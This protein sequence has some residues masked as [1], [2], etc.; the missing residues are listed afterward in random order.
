MKKVLSLIILLIMFVSTPVFSACSEESGNATI[1]SNSILNGINIYSYGA[2]SG[3]TGVQMFNYGVSTFSVTMKNKTGAKYFGYN[4][5]SG[6]TWDSSKSEVCC[7]ALRD[8]RYTKGIKEGFIYLAKLAGNARKSGTNADYIAITDMA[9]RFY[10]MANGISNGT[11]TGTGSGFFQLTNYLQTIYE[12]YNQGQILFGGDYEAI[13]RYVN[14]KIASSKYAHYSLHSFISSDDE[15]QQNH[16]DSLVTQAYNLYI[17]AMDKKRDVENAGF[18]SRRSTPDITIDGS[19]TAINCN[20]GNI[21]FRVETE[22]SVQDVHFLINNNSGISYSFV[23]NILSISQSSIFDDAHCEN[24]S[25]TISIQVTYQGGSD[26]NLYYCSPTSSINK[27]N[28]IVYVGSEGTIGN[29]S[30]TK[31]YN[32]TII[33]PSKCVPSSYSENCY[34][35]EGGRCIEPDNE[36]DNRVVIKSSINNCCFDPI[37]GNTSTVT[38]A[39]ESKSV[40]DDL[41][42]NDLFLF[43]D[44]LSNPDILSVV[45]CGVRT[46]TVAPDFLATTADTETMR[47]YCQMYCMERTQIITPPPVT[48]TAGRYFEIDFTKF[49]VNGERQCRIS[50]DNAAFFAEYMHLVDLQRKSFNAFYYNTAHAYLYKTVA[51]NSFEGENR[52]PEFGKELKIECE[53]ES[54]EVY[55]GSGWNAF[56]VKINGNYVKCDKPSTCTLTFDRLNTASVNYLR[57]PIFKATITEDVYNKNGEIAYGAK[58]TIIKID[59]DGNMSSHAYYKKEPKYGFFAASYQPTGCA[60]PNKT[61]FEKAGSPTCVDYK[62]RPIMD[63]VERYV[64]THCC[65]YD[66]GVS[67]GTSQTTCMSRGGVWSSHCTKVIIEKN[68]YTTGGANFYKNCKLAEYDQGIY[69][70]VTG[71][72]LYPEF[73]D[74]MNQFQ[75]DADDARSNFSAAVSELVKLEQAML[76][77]L[78]FFEGNHYGARDLHNHYDVSKIAASFEYDQIFSTT[79]GGMTTQTIDGLIDKNCEVELVNNYGLFDPDALGQRNYIDLKGFHNSRLKYE[80]NEYVNWSYDGSAT[81]SE[82]LH[83]EAAGLEEANAEIFYKY[84]IIDGTYKAKCDFENISNEYYTLVP[85][86]NSS[87]SPIVD[88][89]V[90]HEKLFPTYVTTYAGKH[91]ILYHVTGLG[92]QIARKF[93]PY[94]QKGTTC[95]GRNSGAY[96]APASCYFEVT[97]KLV[98]TGTCNNVASSSNYQDEC[99]ISCAGDGSCNSIYNFV[100]KN[101]E[102]DNLFPNEPPSLDT[103]NGWGKNWLTTEGRETREKMEQDGKKDLTYS[104]TSLTYSFVL[105]PKTITA[106]KDYNSFRYED[107]GYNDF[108][109]SCNCGAN[110]SNACI[111]CM[112]SFLSDL[113]QRN[114]VETINTSYISE[115]PI[116]GNDISIQEVRNNNHNWD[117][118]NTA[119][120]AKLS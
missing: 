57:Y 15:R 11:A 30:S 119:V 46:M 2:L 31:T 92:S 113:A 47:T 72:G 62:G 20:N 83:S 9:I 116:W 17:K 81:F 22:S 12:F 16:I 87:S 54:G 26:E 86:G 35:G 27:A 13:N 74:D 107:G 101:V 80:V 118:D 21:S 61:W 52:F 8:G 1:Y 85:G 48:V 106:I 64:D 76:D 51:N 110:G 100:F 28:I 97:Q 109:L 29:S 111:K 5:Y 103:E 102:P 56:P 96:N 49:K 65:T 78:H 114:A 44:K 42:I 73:E 66:D 45:K 115:S 39:L 50:L 77:C 117:K 82:Y 68:K 69:D 59:V 112:S 24:G 10:A 34:S 63:K 7:D 25:V 40:D 67:Y 79:S 36:S 18:G 108:G 94:F 41:D 6:N 98:T 84:V 14:D 38:D 70:Y 93:D 43:N 60:D 105:T 37:E 99:N 91:E 120:R 33:V 55:I 3:G 32:T 90:S 75:D 104:P 88:N 89:Y 95:S 23:N 58:N 53:K 19:D 71:E 4:L